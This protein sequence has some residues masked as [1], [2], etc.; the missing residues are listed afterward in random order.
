[1]GERLVKRSSERSIFKKK[2]SV[3]F[4][5]GWQWWWWSQGGVSELGKSVVE[6]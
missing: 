3:Q 5:A 1:M 4:G 6:L 2:K